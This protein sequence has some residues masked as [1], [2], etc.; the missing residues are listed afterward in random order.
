MSE[1]WFS[2]INNG[3]LLNAFILFVIAVFS[4]SSFYIN[5]K[6][7]K[8]DLWEL[9]YKFYKTA[10]NIWGHGGFF[11][12][13]MYVYKLKEKEQLK[14]FTAED[15][16]QLSKLEKS[17]RSNYPNYLKSGTLYT[18]DFA[19]EIQ[20][21]KWLFDEDIASYLQS[22]NPESGGLLYDMGRFK[23]LRNVWENKNPFHLEF[24]KYLNL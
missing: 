24:Q 12:S 22:L 11:H 18:S 16:E 7:Q 3:Q 20:E 21:A 19:S 10:F 17:L 6:K 9:R 13:L 1:G 4:G 23:N 14:S 8:Q 5:L 2:E 15:Q